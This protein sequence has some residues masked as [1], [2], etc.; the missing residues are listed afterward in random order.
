MPRSEAAI[1]SDIEAVH[2]EI[3]TH[4]TALDALYPRRADLFREGRALDPPIS[5]RRLGDHAGVKDEAVRNAVNKPRGGAPAR[6]PAR[7]GG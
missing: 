7:S 6:S 1:L 5:F 4:E 2:A 3:V